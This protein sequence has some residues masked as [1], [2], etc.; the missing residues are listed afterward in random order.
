[1]HDSEEKCGPLQLSGAD[2]GI[3]YSDITHPLTLLVCY[4]CVSHSGNEKL[5]KSGAAQQLSGVT[6][7]YL[8]QQTANSA[9]RPRRVAADRPCGDDGA[10]FAGGGEGCL[11][12]YT[13]VS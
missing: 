10:K 6:Q 8:G 4:Y 11:W 3:R 12:D 7:N 9:S 5:A 13:G 1:M 2:N